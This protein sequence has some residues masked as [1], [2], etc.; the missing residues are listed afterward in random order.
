MGEGTPVIDPPEGHMRTYLDTIRRLSELDLDRIYPGHFRAL[1][2]PSEVLQELLEHRAERERAI[3]RVLQDD[4]AELSDIVRR[5]Y[6]DTA[7]DLHDLAARSALA[8]LEMLE[9][10]DKVVR[11]GR[12]WRWRT[13]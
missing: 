10:D 7:S 13:R 3:V 6:S 9:E 4:A 1:E 12:V 11:D 5:A 8:H 2:R